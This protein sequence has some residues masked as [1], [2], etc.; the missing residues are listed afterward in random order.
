MIFS[1]FSM[2]VSAENDPLTIEEIT[3]VSIAVKYQVFDIKEE[4]SLIRRHL[5]FAFIKRIF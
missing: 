4:I 5:F 2:L 3:K 1:L